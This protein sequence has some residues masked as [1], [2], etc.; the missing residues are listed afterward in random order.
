MMKFQT[1]FP[2][3]AVNLKINTVDFGNA[4][5]SMAAVANYQDCFARMESFQANSSLDDRRLYQFE[6]NL[7]LNLKQHF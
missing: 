6:H 3:D 1:V 2:V 4:S 5:K 7:A